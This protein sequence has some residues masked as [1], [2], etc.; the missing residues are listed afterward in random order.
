MIIGAITNSWREHLVHTDLPRLVARVQNRGAA[1]IE[2]RQTC[3]GQ[4]ES[5]GGDEWR[6][7]TKRLE[8]LYRTFPV[9]SF[10]L[11]VAYPCLTREPDPEAPMF[12]ACLEAAKAVNPVTPRLRLVDTARFDG[13]W[14]VV[15]DLPP[16][17]GGI[18]QMAREAAR[19]GVLLFLENAGQPIRSM[20]L[21]VREA[22]N[23][24]AGDEAGYLGLCIDPINSMRADPDSDPIA[25]IEALPVDHIFMVHFKQTRKG[26]P[27]PTVEE[28]D[29]DYPRLIGVLREKGYD[30]LAVLEIPA[31]E[32]VFDS[33]RA[34]VT[35]LENL[36]G[37]GS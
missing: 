36:M 18:A 5:G 27:H 34:S 22:R 30:G 19:Q 7:D 23:A 17:A 2:L 25:E 4:Y 3:L 35:Y 24:L 32:A 21:V 13:I 12:Q 26:E 37:S 15:E 29:L 11:A 14:K 20:D 28:G 6:P 1:H 16:A 31:E 8:R 9:M 10:N 33:F